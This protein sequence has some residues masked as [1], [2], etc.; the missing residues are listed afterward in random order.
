MLD[1]KFSIKDLGIVKYFLGIEV[2]RNKD[3]ISLCQRKYALDLL[4]DSGLLASKPCSNPLDNNIKLHNK[5]SVPFSDIIAYRR[6]IGRLVYLTHT[7]PDISFSV[8]HLSQFLAAPTIDHFKAALRVL[9]YIKGSPGKGLFFP[10]KNTA[11]LK[12]YSDSDW[13]S[14]IDTRR[15]VTGFCFF[16]GESLIS[17]KSKRQRTVSRSY[18]EAEYRAL[19]ITGCEAQWLLYLLDDLKLSHVGPVAL[20]CDNQST[21]H[22]AANPVFHERTKHIEIDYHSIR[23]RVVNGVLHLLPISSQEQL[24]DIFTKAQTPGVFCANLSKLGLCDIH[25]PTCGGVLNLV[26]SLSNKSAL[27]WCRN[28]PTHMEPGPGVMQHDLV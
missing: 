23:E 16:L 21:L 4:Q 17:W 14:C 6:L 22:I 10:S 19:A 1:D 27:T 3:G 12:G 25:S 8:S 13:A 2:A 7:R 24:A 9:K 5:S 15:S 18:A 20:Y 11:C 26:C 28:G